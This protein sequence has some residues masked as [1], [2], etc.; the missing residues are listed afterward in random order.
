M[1]G[2]GGWTALGS[3]GR[4]VALLRPEPLRVC[5]GPAVGSVVNSTGFLHMELRL[6]S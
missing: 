1:V 2:A 6:S 5:S 3:A 4:T